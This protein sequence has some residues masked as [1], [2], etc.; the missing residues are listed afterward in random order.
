MQ[1]L[2]C[3]CFPSTS[4]SSAFYRS[5]VFFLPYRICSF[6][7]LLIL[8][9]TFGIFELFSNFAYLMSHALGLALIWLVCTDGYLCLAIAHICPGLIPNSDKI[10]SPSGPR[11][12][13]ECYH[14]FS[15]FFLWSCLW[16]LA[17]RATAP[18]IQAIRSAYRASLSLKWLCFCFHW[19]SSSWDFTLRSR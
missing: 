14:T 17:H 19:T 2:K 1:W 5:G 16:S 3:I 18:Q 7:W 6:W 4:L 8:R 15:W 11:F 10:V 12:I 13:E 9:A